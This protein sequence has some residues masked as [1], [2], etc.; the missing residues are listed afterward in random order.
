MS[1]AILVELF[2]QLRSGAYVGVQ[3]VHGSVWEDTPVLAAITRAAVNEV[4]A[5]SAADPSY[6]GPPITRDRVTV[7]HVRPDLLGAYFDLV[8]NRKPTDDRRA[9]ADPLASDVW[10][11]NLGIVAAV[12]LPTEN[13]GGS[14]LDPF[15]LPMHAVVRTRVPGSPEDTLCTPDA[16]GPRAPFGD[17]DAVTCRACLAEVERRRNASQRR[18]GGCFT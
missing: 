11:R 16:P 10:S 9:M 5:E 4:V 12:Y 7:L 13:S 14:G 3:Y 8:R 15:S 1:T 18:Q 17:F 6:D 2:P